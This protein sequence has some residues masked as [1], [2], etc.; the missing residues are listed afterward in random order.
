ML[1][2]NLIKKDIN[3]QRIF[4]PLLLW[5]IFGLV[6]VFCASIFFLW[7]WEILFLRLPFY[8]FL[9]LWL[10]FIYISSVFFKKLKIHTY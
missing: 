1:Q 2:D 9:L 5:P 3:F 8:M 6:M 10:G 7:I 4:S